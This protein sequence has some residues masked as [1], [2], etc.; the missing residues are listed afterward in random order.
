MP[1]A[2]AAATA[3]AIGASICSS[4]NNTGTE[5][6]FKATTDVSLLAFLLE[7]CCNNTYTSSITQ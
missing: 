6:G 4:I 3:A 5:A 1:P 2:V 7:G